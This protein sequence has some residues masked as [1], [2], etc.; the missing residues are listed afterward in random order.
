MLWIHKSS[1]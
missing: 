1:S